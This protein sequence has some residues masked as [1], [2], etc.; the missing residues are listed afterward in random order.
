M[1]FMK[2]GLF[3]CANIGMLLLGVFINN[4]QAANAS[5]NSDV[6][7]S[8]N[9]AKT[10]LVSQHPSSNQGGQV[11]E[12]GKYHLEFVPEPE[13]NGTHM[14]F[15]LQRGNNHQAIPNAKV[16]A[17]VQMPDGTQKTLPLKYDT[18]GKHYTALLAGKAS[19]Q[20]QVKI[21]ADI[22]GEKVNGR[23]SFKR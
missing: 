1:K 9:V 13:A 5:N 10:E 14:D 7:S 2:L 4:N 18:K 8:K 19:G 20:Y 22:K 15:F 12:S 6:Y 16:T 3:V 11:V 23:F 17:Q 21:N